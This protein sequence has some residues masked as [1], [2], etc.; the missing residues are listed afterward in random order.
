[1]YRYTRQ[2]LIRILRISA[3]QLVAWE[4]SG[5]VASADSYTFFDR[6]GALIRTGPTNTNVNDLYVLLAF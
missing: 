1:M 2:D 6:L 4:K 5:L 3:H